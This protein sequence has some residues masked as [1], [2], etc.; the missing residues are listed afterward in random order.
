MTEREYQKLKNRIEQECKEKLRALDVVWQ[1][2]RNAS[3][4]GQ[5]EG[6]Q[7][8]EI[9]AGKG[10]LLNAI[11]QAL[12]DIHGRFSIH[13]VE[14]GVQGNSPDLIVQRSSISGALKRLAESKEIEIVEAGSG[15]RPSVYQKA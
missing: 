5:P 7:K 9:T 1:L 14:K 10:K 6:Q 4:N 12:T 2:A 15:K 3:S 11:R 13:E 8:R